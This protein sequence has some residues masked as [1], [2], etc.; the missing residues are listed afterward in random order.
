MKIKRI[1]LFFALATQA[2]S[3]QPAC[4]AS[5][6]RALTDA[7]L[8]EGFES[9]GVCI[10][11]SRA[12][13]TFENR[14]YRYDIRAL[15]AVAEVASIH[16]IGVQALRLIPTRTGLPLVTIDL[17]AS[18]PPLAPEVVTGELAT[19]PRPVSQNGPWLKLDAVLHPVVRAQFGDPDNPI[20][21]DLELHPTLETALWPGATATA[22][23]VVPVLNDIPDT[24]L[25]NND[26]SIR[27]GI[28]AVHQQLRLPGATFARMSAGRFTQNRYGVDVQATS[29]L[30]NGHVAVSARVGQTGFARFDGSRLQYSALDLTTFAASIE[31]VVAPR[32]ALT[33]RA[34]VERYL[35]E[36]TGVRGELARQFGETRIGFF[37]TWTESARSE[38]RFNVGGRIAFALPVARHARPGRVRARLADRMEIEYRYRRLTEGTP[39]YEVVPVPED[40]LGPLNPPLLGAH[41]D[42][43]VE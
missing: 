36:K 43:R 41:L 18:R 25:Q 21:A 3:A 37:G 2:V 27:P 29:Y 22:Q 31:A 9:V 4:D 32:Y 15:E 20:R 16:L 11:A 19:P 17:P 33:A 8:A 34:S 10:E 6:A 39:S 5:G 26:R 13:V 12:V 42:R 38:D 40:A 24:G 28:L 23:L 7:L 30:A 35:S 1:A 14:L